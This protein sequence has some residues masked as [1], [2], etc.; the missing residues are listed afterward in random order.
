MVLPD[1]SGDGAQRSFNQ[2]HEYFVGGSTFCLIFVN[3]ELGIGTQGNDAPIL[4]DKVNF[5][6][7]SS[8]DGLTFIYLLAQRHSNGCPFSSVTVAFPWK[9]STEANNSAAYEILQVNKVIKSTI[10]TLTFD[11]PGFQR[12]KA[13]FQLALH[14]A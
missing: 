6:I 3:P 10:M 14:L 8:S 5:A 4:C 13:L 11:P 12:V 1:P 2:G 7:G 9:A